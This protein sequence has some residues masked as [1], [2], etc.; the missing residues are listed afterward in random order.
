MNEPMPAVPGEPEVEAPPEIAMRAQPAQSVDPKHLA[1][2][3]RQML[4]Q[5][6]SEWLDIAESIE[7]A[8]L[9]AL[10]DV[11]IEQLAQVREHLSVAARHGLSAAVN[12]LRK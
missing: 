2:G 11:V 6:S 12:L 5:R 3:V 1:R 9:M 8:E 4:L 7:D 10:P